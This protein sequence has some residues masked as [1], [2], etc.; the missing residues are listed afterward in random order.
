MRGRLALARAG[1]LLVLALLG[2]TLL[3][4][5]SLQRLLPVP[6]APLPWLPL[7]ALGL[8]GAL[9][10]A[11]LTRGSPLPAALVVLVPV[12]AAASYGESRLDWLRTLKDFGVAEE[13][14]PSLARLG[15]GFAALAAAWALHVVDTS[16]RL[17]W[18]S[19]DRGI[20]AAQARAASRVSLRRGA[21]VGAMA[22]GGAL[23]T[24][25]LV[26]GAALV[27][28][29]VLPVE[30]MSFL[31]PLLAALLLAAAALLLVGVPRKD[32]G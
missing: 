28:P 24:A 9:L 12:L 1:P 10:P 23:L 8:L 18:R 26:L 29:L 11:L 4:T 19:V 21:L 15:L 32:E 7:L 6:L 27:G 20:P 14:G 22:L 30:R 3:L 31:A 13:Q 25:V 2:A 5:S 16:L 17:R